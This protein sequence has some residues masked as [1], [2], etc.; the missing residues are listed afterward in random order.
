MKSAEFFEGK[1]DN[2]ESKIS[3]SHKQ[4]LQQMPLGICSKFM[5][6]YVLF[7]EDAR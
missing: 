6:D 3:W 5:K 1:A 7:I 4:I 2:N